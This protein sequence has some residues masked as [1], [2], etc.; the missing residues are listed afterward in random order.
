MLPTT[1]RKQLR[2]PHH[3]AILCAGLSLACAFFIDL[4]QSDR[5]EDTGAIHQ[6]LIEVK[7]K[8]P[9]PEQ[10]SKTQRGSLSL[11][12]LFPWAPYRPKSE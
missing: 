8:E 9:S 5:M 7:A 4:T 11:P 12:R 1:A 10:T 3:V 2:I 6:T